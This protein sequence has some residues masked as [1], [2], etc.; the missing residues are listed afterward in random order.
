MLPSRQAS[1][2][3]RE[4]RRTPS[5]PGLKDVAVCL[6]RRLTNREHHAA[7][8]AIIAAIYAVAMSV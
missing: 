6:V 5:A 8:A 3:P 1:P 4:A 7:R 2:S